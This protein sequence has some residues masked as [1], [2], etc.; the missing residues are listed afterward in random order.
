MLGIL[1]SKIRKSTWRVRPSPDLQ[2]VLKYFNIMIFP[3]CV[4][5]ERGKFIFIRAKINLVGGRRHAYFRVEGILRIPYRPE[6]LGLN[7]IIH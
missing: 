2:M 6:S 7:I 5:T 3:Y 4:M 1:V